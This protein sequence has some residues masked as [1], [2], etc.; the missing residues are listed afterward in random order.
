MF[1]NI[2]RK[3][4]MLAKVIC[5]IGIIFSL[6]AGIILIAIGAQHWNGEVTVITG[7]I[8]LILGPISSWLGSF[9]LYGFGELIDSTQAIR[10]RIAPE[11]IPQPYYPQQPTYQE[12]YQNQT[13]YQ[14]PQQ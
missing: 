11:Q 12:P 8:V 1:K 10:N 6:I 9:T 2:G 5:W 4:K 3:I 13:D 14:N 7:V